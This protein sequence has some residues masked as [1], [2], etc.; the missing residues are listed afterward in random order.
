MFHLRSRAARSSSEAEKP[1]WISY[2]DLMTA[3]M[4]LFLAVMSVTL[5]VVTRKIDAAE[6]RQL[7]R[8]TEVRALVQRITV[9]TEPFAGMEVSARDG[10]ISFGEG[11]RFERGGYAIAPEAARL[12]RSYARN[13][14]KALPAGRD[15][16]WL[17][18]V[19]VEGFTDSDGSYLYN[20]ELSL[21]RSHS[22]V[23]TL[24]AA[25][26]ANETALSAAELAQI[27]DLFLVGG[28][29][30]NGAKRTKEAS[31]RVEFRLELRAADEAPEVR[32]AGAAEQFGRCGVF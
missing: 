23:C 17:R 28:F 1:F 22:V 15:A 29:S 6:R 25:P 27:R 30:F 11:V 12:L 4:V 5:M 7:E 32:T 20:L 16:G 8:D 13:L 21:R 19:V 24:F 14:L 9:A 18:H 10:R 2:A 26:E 3:L 31:R